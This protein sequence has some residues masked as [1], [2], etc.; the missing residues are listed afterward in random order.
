M[1]EK[2]K[3]EGIEVLNDQIQRFQDVFWDPEKELDFI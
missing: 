1:E 3:S 2:L